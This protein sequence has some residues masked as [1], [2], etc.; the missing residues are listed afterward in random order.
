MLTAIVVQSNKQLTIIWTTQKYTCVCTE[1]FYS[2]YH[3]SWSNAVCVSLYV[4]G[5]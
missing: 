3:I 5:C 4:A 1:Y 2:A